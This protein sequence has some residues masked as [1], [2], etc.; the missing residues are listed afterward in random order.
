[1]PSYEVIVKRRIVEWFTF[2]ADSKEDAEQLAKKII[3]AYPPIYNWA[4]YG[5][6]EYDV[7]ALQASK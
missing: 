2:E 3:D 4:D 6:I 1:M 7:L 5:P